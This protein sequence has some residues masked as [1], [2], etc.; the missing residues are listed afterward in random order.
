MVGFMLCCETE[1]FLPYQKTRMSWSLV[2]LALQC[3]MVSPKG[4][5]EGEEYL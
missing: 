4:T 2:I 1:Y 3:E 5:Q